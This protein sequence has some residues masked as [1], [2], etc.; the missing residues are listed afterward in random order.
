MYAPEDTAYPFHILAGFSSLDSLVELLPPPEELFSYLDLFQRNAQSC[1]VP[2]TSNELPMP[3]SEVERFLEDGH[4][5]ASNSPDAL[6]LLFAM[7]ATGM[8]VGSYD[9]NGGEWVEGAVE[10]SRQQ[11]DVYS[12][13]SSLL[14]YQCIQLIMAC[15]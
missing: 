7:I 10:E 3:R 4:R 9:R 2:Q 13:S 14:L 1:S 12:K 8:Q 5:N 11:S 15:S 6:A